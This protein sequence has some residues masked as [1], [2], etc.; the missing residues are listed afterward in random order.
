MHGALLFFAS[1][2]KLCIE[3]L[4]FF[5]PFLSLKIY[6]LISGE[7]MFGRD[8]D[9]R[10]VPYLHTIILGDYPLDFIKKGKY[11]DVFF[12]NDGKSTFYF[13]LGRQ[14]CQT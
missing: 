12:N 9:D 7:S 5:F 4:K 1:W 8:I 6:E 10:S 3:V 14:I 2:F 13:N 11:S